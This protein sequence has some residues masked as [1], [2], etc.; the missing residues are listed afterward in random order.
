VTLHVFVDN[1][2][3]FAG[4]QRVAKHV[5]AYV[6]WPAIRLYVRNF[7]TLIEG[8]KPVATRV[9]AGSVP[10]GSEDLWQYARDRGYNTDLLRKVETDDGRLAEQGVDELLHLKI[11]NVLL[12]ADQPEVLVLATGDGRVTTY[13]TGFGLQAE[14]ALK[15]DWC[16]EVWS[17][18]EQ[19]SGTFA[20]LGK[21]YP[22]R[23]HVHE[24][25]PFYYSITFVKPGT[26]TVPRSIGPVSLGNRSVVVADRVVSALPAGL[27]VY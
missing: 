20:R 22:G 1:S 27:K 24:L 17:W 12:D 4:A 8:S 2:N 16:V 18:R 11:A 3:I 26:Y 5:E 10:P 23:L 21:L 19:L 15:R 14:R 6:P 9:Y 13:G 25:D 7:I